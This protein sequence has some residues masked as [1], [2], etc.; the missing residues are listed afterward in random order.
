MACS[1]SAPAPKPSRDTGEPRPPQAPVEPDWRPFD[2]ATDLGPQEPPPG[3]GPALEWFADAKS[4]LWGA[5]VFTFLLVS[6]LLTVRA[7]GF[8]WMRTWWLWLILVGC[9]SLFLLARK[10]LRTTAG[11]DWLRMDQQW[12][13]T[14]RLRSIRV[15]RGARTHHLELV[16]QAGNKL[17]TQVYY[18]Q[19]NR[20]LWDL[21]FNGILH[22]IVHSGADVNR[23]AVDHLHLKAAIRKTPL[24]K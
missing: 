6:V 1:D 23:R 19:K 22:S 9:C 11:S 16:D 5:A 8:G 24:E 4:T 18:L 2:K 12:V 21:V 7:G 15:T 3:K 17:H 10:K 14:Y 13:D 20:R